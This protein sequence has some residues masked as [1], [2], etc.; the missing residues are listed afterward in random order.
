MDG[1]VNGVDCGGGR[2]GDT[3]GAGTMAETERQRR[4]REEL[5][6]ALA[7]SWAM[8]AWFAIFLALMAPWVMI[9][10]SSSFDLSAEPFHTIGLVAV[11]LLAFAVIT[12][13]VARLCWREPR[14]R[15][16]WRWWVV[17]IGGMLLFVASLPLVGTLLL[18]MT[19]SEGILT[20]SMALG[21]V[22]VGAVAAA[23]LIWMEEAGRDE[24]AV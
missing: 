21:F 12:V 4:R 23:L 13:R 7:S 9:G 15:R 2:C 14:M 11:S 8:S 1:L 24:E 16:H 3:D 20:A 10:V 6:R 5:D 22:W 17:C 19:P 18:G